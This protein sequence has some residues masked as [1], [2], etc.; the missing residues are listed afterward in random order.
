MVSGAAGYNVN[1]LQTAQFFIADTYLGEINAPILQIMMQGIAD[2]L[3]LLVNLLHHEMLKAAFF[4]RLSI[5]LYRYSL[6]LNFFSVNIV[7]MNCR[8][9]Q[10][11]NFHVADVINLS[12]IF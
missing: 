7:K 3:G 6:F 12:G 4:R 1:S 9:F 10:H 11:S 2:N 8:I 5:P